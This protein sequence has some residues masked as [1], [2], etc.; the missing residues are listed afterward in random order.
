[1]NIKSKSIG[2]AVVFGV[3]V[4]FLLFRRPLE[5]FATDKIAESINEFEYTLI[6]GNN[7]E[8]NV[9]GFFK[10]D[11]YYLFL[12]SGVKTWKVSNIDTDD[13]VWI[14]DDVMEFYNASKD[15]TQVVPFI[16][17]CSENIGS[18]FLDLGE[19]SREYLDSLYKGK[20]PG[21][22]EIFTSDGNLDSN[23]ELKFIR[24][25]GN[26]TYN[27]AKKPY[28]IKFN[29][30]TSV[31]GMKKAKQWVLLANHYDR[32]LL[33]N[34]LVY[35]FAKNYT[36]LK[37]EEGRYVDVFVNGEF[38][39]NYY[40]CEKVEVGKNRVNITDQ[41]KNSENTEI[42]DIT[43]GYLLEL[44]P[45]FLIR[46]NTIY[47]TTD[48]GFHYE[49]KSPENPTPEQ[50]E[51]IKGVFN[52]LESA[53]K[54]ED[55]YSKISGRHYSEIMDIDSYVQKYLVE[56]LFM[57]TDIDY[58][59]QY[60]YKDSDAV[61]SKLYAGPVW[62]YDMAI[63]YNSEPYVFEQFYLQEDLLKFV[64][65]K[66]RCLDLYDKI[67]KTYVEE[68]L[69][70]D[71]D[72]YSK[73]IEQSFN[74]NMVRW[75]G[76]FEDFSYGYSTIQGNVDFI[77]DRLHERI[78]Y[79]D[80]LLLGGAEDY[81]YVKF[82]ENSYTAKVKEGEK[83]GKINGAAANWYQ[84]FDG[85]AFDGTDDKITEDTVVNEDVNCHA[86]MLDADIVMS[87]SLNELKESNIDLSGLNPNDLDKIADMIERMQQK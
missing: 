54:S 41:D 43:G 71:L 25:R 22:V 70:K 72:A 62:D 31:L 85:W 3:C 2:A 17:M 61:D 19:N 42:K 66:N 30:K 16:V 73:T 26:G 78:K 13:S 5:A 12:P 64:E 1:M 83:I 32:S 76:T 20:L 48:S 45:D 34:K 4:L 28:E 39:G 87:K 35:D 50:I 36:T 23:T 53:A 51:Y 14:H 6:M 57:N 75:N 18:L 63:H 29:E 24:T 55:G 38:L 58:N 47:F 67:F 56:T 21:S 44:L 86:R 33:R 8:E 37:S 74:M 52:D 11:S 65:V 46:E 84:L 59:S 10:N 40:L 15:K 80:E 68:D 82:T 49:I 60:Y 81:R 27:G 9:T 79:M 7:Y 77:K 69:Q